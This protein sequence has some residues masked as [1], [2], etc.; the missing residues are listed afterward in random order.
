MGAPQTLAER[1]NSPIN[2]T[3]WGHRAV[4]N[5][6]LSSALVTG[7][8]W[9]AAHYTN[10]KYDALVKSF[11]AALALKDQRK[12]SKQIETVLLHDTPVIFPYFY[13]YIAAGSKNVKGYKSDALGEIYVSKTSLA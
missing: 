10:K 7:G 4:P 1:T 8:I 6:L 2:I 3:D 13:Y 11:Q 12:Y 9:N 5:V